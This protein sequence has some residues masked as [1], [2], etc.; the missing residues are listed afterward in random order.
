[1]PGSCIRSSRSS[2]EGGLDR[3]RAVEKEEMKEEARSL[4]Q[5]R[6]KLARDRARQ[7]GA[8]SNVGGVD[9]AGGLL[10]VIDFMLDL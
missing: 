2:I 10:D 5:A 1:M 7:S 8:L 4:R 9:D 6:E 3:V